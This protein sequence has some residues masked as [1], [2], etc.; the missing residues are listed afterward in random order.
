M[1]TTKTAKLDPLKLP[2]LDPLRR[3]SIDIASAY[4]GLSR[5]R[6][7]QEIAAGRLPTIKE[8]KRRFVPGAVIAARS[9]AEAAA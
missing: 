8:G 9:G 3:Y 1:E 6:V 7:Y 5:A 4:L 2:P